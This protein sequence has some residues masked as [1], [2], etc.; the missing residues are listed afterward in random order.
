MPVNAVS[1]PHVEKVKHIAQIIAI[2][3]QLNADIKHLPVRNIILKTFIE[4]KRELNSLPYTS[5]M[6]ALLCW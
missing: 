6:H 5:V 4:M 3:F 1:F 2:C